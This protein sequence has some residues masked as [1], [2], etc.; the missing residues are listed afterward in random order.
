[1][2][3][4]SVKHS[5]PCLILT[6]NSMRQV[7]FSPFQRKLMYRESYRDI[8]LFPKDHIF[9]VKGSPV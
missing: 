1:M 6:T 7:L 5:L 9:N 8:K 3:Q 4:I 2:Y